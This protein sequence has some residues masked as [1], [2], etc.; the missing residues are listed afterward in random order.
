LQTEGSTD[1]HAG[2]GTIEPRNLIQNNEQNAVKTK[3][4][5]WF[6]VIPSRYRRTKHVK[7]DPGK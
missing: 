6:E 7:I 1:E 5:K 3:E 4:N 2:Y